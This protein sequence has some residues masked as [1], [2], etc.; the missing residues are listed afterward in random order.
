MGLGLGLGLGNNGVGD[1]PLV[2]GGAR[3]VLGDDGHSLRRLQ[4]YDEVALAW[5]Y[6]WGG[7]LVYIGLG[8]GSHSRVGFLSTF[9]GSGLGLEDG[10]IG[11]DGLGS[12][13]GLGVGLRCVRVR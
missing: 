6:Q 10:M 4:P 11:V 12:G 3:V 13:F 2:V 1:L 7:P 9:L 8:T 5:L